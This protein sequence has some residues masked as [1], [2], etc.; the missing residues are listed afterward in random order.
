MASRLCEK[1][2]VGEVHAQQ[3]DSPSAHLD[4]QTDSHIWR[5]ACV[6]E[7]FRVREV[8]AAVLSQTKL[9]DLPKAEPK[10]ELSENEFRL[11]SLDVSESVALELAARIDDDQI[12]RLKPP[13]NV[14]YANGQEPLGMLQ[15]IER[16]STTAHQHGLVF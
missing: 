7:R 16:L 14:I 12:V 13:A 3:S 15:F 2:V 10:L 5:V 4:C 11:G 6:G 8:R 9:D 1:M